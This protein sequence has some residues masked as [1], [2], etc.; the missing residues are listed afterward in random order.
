MTTATYVSQRTSAGR[1]MVHIQRKF[2]FFCPVG[3]N[4]SRSTLTNGTHTGSLKTMDA[5]RDVHQS[6]DAPLPS[7][8]TRDD[9][10]SRVSVSVAI[11]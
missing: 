7:V 10:R 5:S 9:R 6:H 8:P 2:P 1:S 11:R 4:A 3:A